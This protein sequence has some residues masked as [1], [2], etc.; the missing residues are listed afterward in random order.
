MVYRIL[1]KNVHKKNSFI[2][3]IDTNNSFYKVYINIMLYYNRF[4]SHFLIK[5]RLKVFI[6]RKFIGINLKKD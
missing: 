6:G 4:L 1:I 2:S 3:T 5:F